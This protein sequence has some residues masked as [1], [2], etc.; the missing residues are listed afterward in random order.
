M[1]TSILRTCGATALV[2]STLFI[3]SPL[4]AGQADAP[5]VSTAKSIPGDGIRSVA[6][7][8]ADLNLRSDG[9]VER[10][11]GRVHRAAQFVCDLGTRVEAVEQR[12]DGR[13]C[14]KGA[15]GR[16]SRDIAVVVAEARSTD[17]LASRGSGRAIRI[18]SR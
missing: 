7:S 2:A 16:A 6:V 10:L 8:Y 4:F 3:A 18:S 15:M 1:Q 13:N 12:Q 5:I 11:N 9:G 17:Q 14:Y